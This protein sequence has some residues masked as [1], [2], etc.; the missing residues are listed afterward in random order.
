MFDALKKQN[1]KN[2]IKA[3]MSGIALLLTYVI[4]S[5]IAALLGNP[6]LIYPAFVLTAGIT[7]PAAFIAADWI[8]DRIRE[9]WLRSDD[10]IRQQKFIVDRLHEELRLLKSVPMSEKDKA[11]ESTRIYRE[12]DTSI[13]KLEAQYLASQTVQ[14]SGLPTQPLVSSNARD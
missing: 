7:G 8:W 6:I 12:Y 14:S 3:L 9:R 2:L 4:A 13:K 11:K 5:G 1:L 10:Y